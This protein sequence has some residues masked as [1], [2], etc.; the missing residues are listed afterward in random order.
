MNTIL[1]ISEKINKNVEKEGRLVDHSLVQSMFKLL[2][3]CKKREF[4]GQ[5]FLQLNCPFSSHLL[6]LLS[7][8]TIIID[9][10]ITLLKDLSVQEN[11]FHS[12]T[13]WSRIRISI[14]YLF[15]GYPYSDRVLDR[16]NGCMAPCSRRQCIFFC[17]SPKWISLLMVNS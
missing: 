2:R 16:P 8:I 12:R 15:I 7:I 9:I 14:F 13:D 1:L 10:S 4:Y 3:N 5:F 6:L 11:F 17:C